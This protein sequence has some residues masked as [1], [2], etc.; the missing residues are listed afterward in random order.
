MPTEPDSTAWRRFVAR[1]SG[2]TPQQLEIISA[3]IDVTKASRGLSSVPVSDRSPRRLGT[4][5]LLRV[6]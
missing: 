1:V 4:G 3:L 2:L 6:L 5:P